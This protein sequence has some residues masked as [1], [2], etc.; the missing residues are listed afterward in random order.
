VVHLDDERKAG[1]DE[2]AK[3][4]DPDVELRIA[5]GL[6]AGGH[7]LLPRSIGVLYEEVDV[8][9]GTRERILVVLGDLR[10]L[11]QHHGACHR[12]ESAL[13]HERGDQRRCSRRAHCGDGVQ[14]GC[15]AERSI[16]LRREQVYAVK[17]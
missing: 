9:V 5:G 10:P 16:V 6:E 12:G 3:M 2:R 14:R 7:Q 1:Q 11:H 4:M 17:A 8:A 13:E 15:P